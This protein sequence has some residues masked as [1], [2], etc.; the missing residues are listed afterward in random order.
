M[1]NPPEDVDDSAELSQ[2]VLFYFSSVLQYEIQQLVDKLLRI[3]FIRDG[4]LF[5]DFFRIHQSRSLPPLRP[6]SSATHIHAPISDS[7]VSVGQIGMPSFQHTTAPAKSGISPPPFGRSESLKK[8]QSEAKDRKPP[9]ALELG[10]LNME[11]RS[12]FSHKNRDHQRKSSDYTRPVS[13][14]YCRDD[15]ED[16]DDLEVQINAQLHTERRGLYARPSR[17]QKQGDAHG[18][19]RR[20]LDS[21]EVLCWSRD[22]GHL[23]VQ[24][25][26]NPRIFKSNDRSQPGALA[27]FLT[28][29]GDAA[30]ED[31]LENV[32]RVSRHSNDLGRVG[33]QAH[34]P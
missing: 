30:T 15:D 10:N 12:V 29:Q 32:A 5:K 19:G 1:V 23:G 21:S 16:E 25:S 6:A 24:Q 27:K 4:Q 8:N 34:H 9:Y 31:G 33:S 7:H 28:P 18:N 2:G 22:N 14:R 20:D 17:A 13:N 3:P 11:E 26:G